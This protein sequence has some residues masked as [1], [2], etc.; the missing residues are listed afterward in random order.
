MTNEIITFWI[1]TKITTEKRKKYL[2]ECINSILKQSS[3]NFEIIISNDNS[4]INV[5]W[6]KYKNNPQIK[7]FHQKKS[8]WIFKNFN[9]CLEKTN[10]KWFIPM[11]DD[12]L[13]ENNF[14]ETIL[15]ISKNNLGVE[16]IYFNHKNIDWDW[17]IFNKT[18]ILLKDWDYYYMK[19]KKYNY[20]QLLWSSPSSF[21][22]IVDVKKIK[23]LWGFPD[24]WMTTDW[25]IAFLYFLKF[26]GYFKNVYIAKLRRH[27]EN[28]SWYNDVILFMDERINLINIIIEKFWEEL[29]WNWIDYLNNEKKYIKYSHI[30]LMKNF[31]D[32]WRL[33]GIKFWIEYFKNSKNIIKTIIIFIIWIILW[34]NIQ[35]GF[36]FISIIYENTNSKIRWLIIN[37][38]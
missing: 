14:I 23:K 28:A 29:Q 32:Y 38:K 2:Y 26:K 17:K 27:S 36:N 21:F 33:K 6:D 24:Y 31:R 13:I 25:Y 19:N 9:F 5:N 20:S 18:K 12:D 37:N 15:E 4:T 22:S 3:N 16:L 1:A 11:W 7:I 34:K 35:K 30:K 10:S 8:L